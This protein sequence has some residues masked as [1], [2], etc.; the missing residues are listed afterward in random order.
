[1]RVRW[2][3]HPPLPRS[4]R[5]LRRAA[6]IGQRAGCYVTSTTDGVHS[7]GSF[8]YQRRAID[9]GSADPTNRRE[10]LAQIR[11]RR[12]MGRRK[13][14]ELFGPAPWYVKDGVVRPGVFP[15]HDDH[16]HAAT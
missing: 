14:R 15:A 5:K 11:I 8:H 3:G 4:R 6:R 2:N 10:A 16:L 12:K 1:M 9:M 7:P 13:F